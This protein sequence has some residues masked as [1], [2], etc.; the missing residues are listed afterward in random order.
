MCSQ[1]SW[2]GGLWGEKVITLGADLSSSV[3]VDNNKKDVIF[4]GEGLTQGLDDTRITAEAKYANNFTESGKRFASS[5]HYN[6]SNSSLFVNAVKMY[7]FKAIDSEI[8]P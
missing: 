7:Q 4:F 8:K 2:L 1:F 5:L 6:G 3:H